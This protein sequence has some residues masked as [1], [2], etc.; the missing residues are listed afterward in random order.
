M[1]FSGR[2]SALGTVFFIAGMIITIYQLT[3]LANT[4]LVAFGS[5]LAFAGIVLFISI[6]GVII[7][8]EKE[9][10]KPYINLIVTKMGKWRSLDPYEKIVL[11]YTSQSQRMNSRGNSTSYV[12]KSFNIV[13]SSSQRKDMIVKDFTDYGKAK[14]FLA[15][16]SIRLRKPKLDTYEQRNHRPQERKQQ[17]RR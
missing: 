8:S 9:K 7:D 6:R 11:K 16:Y 17:S 4:F 12:T 14:A 5:V 2:T 15:D 13:L 10:I 3:H 1:T